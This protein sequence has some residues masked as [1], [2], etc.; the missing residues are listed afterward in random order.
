MANVQ[1]VVYFYRHTIKTLLFLDCW[2]Q[3][4]QLF[5]ISS[6]SHEQNPCYGRLYL[7]RDLSYN[8]VKALLSNPAS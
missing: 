6:M 2:Y 4:K 3:N 5:K 1:I 8:Q 7:R